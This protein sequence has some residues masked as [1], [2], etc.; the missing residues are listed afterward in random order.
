MKKAWLSGLFFFLAFLLRAQD[1]IPLKI[2]VGLNV[3]PLFYNS[4]NL[5]GG[6]KLSRY[7]SFAINGGGTFFKKVNT[8]NAYNNYTNGFF[9]KGGPRFTLH[10]DKALLEDHFFTGIEWGVSYFEHSFD[11][12]ITHAFGSYKEPFYITD[13]TTG[14][15]IPFGLVLYVSDKVSIEQ[16]ISFNIVKP[17][18]DG[19]APYKY[20][21]PGFG[22]VKQNNMEDNLIN[23]N[24]FF[25]INYSF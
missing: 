23:A 17:R 5:Q 7:L 12:E 11:V 1:T 21:L 10:V 13:A 25:K 18:T 14:F 22:I 3:I 19:L 24:V 8:E 15:T 9:I 4:V 20:Y 6:Y 16:G 2:T